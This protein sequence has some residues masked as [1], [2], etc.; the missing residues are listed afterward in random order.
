MR[1]KELGYNP[2]VFLVMRFV[3]SGN[4][5]QKA[6]RIGVSWS[7]DLPTESPSKC[8]RADVP[9]STAQRVYALKARSSNILRPFI[10]RF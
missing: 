6:K 7:S 10:I 4:V 2:R 5:R 1:R 3:L 8:S 9:S